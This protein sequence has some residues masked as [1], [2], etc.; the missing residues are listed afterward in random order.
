VLKLNFSGIKR[1]ECELADNWE[2]NSTT[3]I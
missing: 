3:W 1:V 2:L